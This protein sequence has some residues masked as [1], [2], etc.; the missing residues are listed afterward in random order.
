MVFSLSL[1]KSSSLS[2]SLSQALSLSNSN[3]EMKKEVEGFKTL[4]D[5]I[6]RQNSINCNVWR[7][8]PSDRV[9]FFKKI[10]GS[11][12]L[13]KFIIF[14]PDLVNVDQRS[15][16]LFVEML[17]DFWPTGPI[18]LEIRT[19]YLSVGTSAALVH[20]PGLFVAMSVSLCDGFFF[21]SAF[22]IGKSKIFS[23][24]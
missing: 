8:I 4:S 17:S 23:S 16:G 1:S 9:Y 6:F 10:T 19:E 3:S 14:G 18:P 11:I 13:K 7:N 20:F 2:L 21:R 15:D 12:S 5:G 24:V 22:S